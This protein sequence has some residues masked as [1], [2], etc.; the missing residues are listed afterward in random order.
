MAAKLLLPKRIGQKQLQWKES[1]QSAGYYR[2]TPLVSPEFDKEMKLERQGFEEDSSSRLLGIA[3]TA[4]MGINPSLMVLSS[5]IAIKEDGSEC[6]YTPTPEFNR[7]LDPKR[8]RRMKE[9]GMMEMFTTE[10]GAE[11]HSQPY[12][13]FPYSFGDTGV[14]LKDL[15]T[16]DEG[17]FAGDANTPGLL[18]SSVK[19]LWGSYFQQSKDE[20]DQLVKKNS[21]DTNKDWLLVLSILMRKICTAFGRFEKKADFKHFLCHLLDV[22]QDSGKKKGPAEGT[23]HLEDLHIHSL[24]ETVLLSK[25]L[26]VSLGFP[27]VAAIEGSARLYCANMTLLGDVAGMDSTLESFVDSNDRMPTGLRAAQASVHLYGIQ[28]V[29]KKENLFELYKKSISLQDNVEKAAPIELCSLIP[30]LCEHFALQKHQQ[31][32]MCKH[33]NGGKISTAIKEHQNEPLRKVLENMQNNSPTIAKLLANQNCELL[34]LCGRHS[35]RSKNSARVRYFSILLGIMDIDF[36]DENIKCT[37]PHLALKKLFVSNGEYLNARERCKTFPW[38]PPGT[39]HPN[40]NDG[41][42]VLLTFKKQVVTPL[43]TRLHAV[44]MDCCRPK[45]S[46]DIARYK[47]SEFF[48]TEW[49]YAYLWELIHWGGI[50]IKFPFGEFPGLEIVKELLKPVTV[51]ALEENK[52]THNENKDTDK[53]GKDKNKENKDTNKGGKD[54]DGEDENGEDKEVKDNSKGNGKTGGIATIARHLKNAYDIDLTFN[55]F[56]AA[57]FVVQHIANREKAIRE[58]GDI[59][60]GQLSFVEL[61]ATPVKSED[62]FNACMQKV[63]PLFVISHNGKDR[64]VS[65]FELTKWLFSSHSEEAKKAVEAVNDSLRKHIDNGHMQLE[66]LMSFTRG[67]DDKRISKLFNIMLLPSSE[68][69]HLV[70]GK[71]LLAIGEETSDP[72]PN[73]EDTNENKEESPMDVD[74]EDERNDGSKYMETEEEEEKA[75]TD[76]LVATKKPRRAKSA[77]SAKATKATKATKGRNQQKSRGSQQSKQSQKIWRQQQSNRKNK[78]EEEEKRNEKGLKKFFN[79]IAVALE[80]KEFQKAV[81]M[82]H[83]AK[84]RFVEEPS[85]TKR[86]KPN[87]YLTSSSADENNSAETTLDFTLGTEKPILYDYFWKENLPQDSDKFCTGVKEL[88]LKKN[89]G[90]ATQ[91]DHGGRAGL[92]VCSFKKVHFQETSPHQGEYNDKNEATDKV[93]AHIAGC[94]VTYGVVLNDRLKFLPTYHQTDVHIKKSLSFLFPE[95]NKDFTCIVVVVLRGTFWT[96]VAVPNAATKHHAEHQER[97]NFE[98]WKVDLG[99]LEK[100]MV[101]EFEEQF[102]DI[103]NRTNANTR[104]VPFENK[105]GSI[106]KFPGGWIHATIFFGTE[107][108]ELLILAYN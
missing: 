105:P 38:I 70:A 52:P 15:S 73:S 103:A 32:P 66:T 13:L 54:E 57:T 74:D 104:I 35:Q 25:I 80:K 8:L 88:V 81:K 99:N 64:K 19:G 77:K 39:P 18:V 11:T 102:K 42:L 12:S 4:S 43:V 94:L 106:L 5:G 85:P 27:V 46:K 79:D 61:F 76:N 84:R 49:L 21:I 93:W 1:G 107:P 44:F 6:C 24:G 90:C 37:S 98:N 53:D 41:F 58:A 108:Q 34:K 29:L 36:G 17:K 33:N 67:S 100:E 23:L 63:C 86:H 28:G 92:P 95:D 62:D 83:D 50:N 68:R 31:L 65:L 7:R 96:L 14:P 40:D 72:N 51:T 2:E 97:K 26:W 3:N 30:E 47:V 56:G 71:T 9:T 55:L 22:F 20:I 75:H 69:S 48:L 10:A 59:G 91:Q 89:A 101:T 16:T 60:E 87:Q 82:T 45:G 78:S